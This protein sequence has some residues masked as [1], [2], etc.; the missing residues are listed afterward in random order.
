MYIEYQVYEYNTKYYY[1]YTCIIEILKTNKK[2]IN[3]FRS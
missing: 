2:Y 1:K 3:D